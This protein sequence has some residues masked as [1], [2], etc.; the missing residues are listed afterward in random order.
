MDVNN[1]ASVSNVAVNNVPKQYVDKARFN[2]SVNAVDNEDALKVSIHEVYNK[3]EMNY[4]I[5]LET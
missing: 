4:P 2:G 1:L 3:K 5:H